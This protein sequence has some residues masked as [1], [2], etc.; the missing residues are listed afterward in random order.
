MFTKIRNSFTLQVYCFAAGIAL[1]CLLLMVLTWLQGPRVRSATLDANLVTTAANQQ[2][3]LHMNQPPGTISQKQVRITPEALFAVTSSGNTVAIQFTQ[4]L[5]NDT[6]YTVAI[7]TSNKRYTVNHT[8]HTAA[9]TFYYAVDSEYSTEIRK[10]TVGTDVSQAVYTGSQVDDYLVLGNTLVL[11]IKDGDKDTLLVYD[12]PSKQSQ[13]VTLPGNGTISQLHSAPGKRLFGFISTDYTS[14][15]TGTILLYDMNAQRLRRVGFS[16]DRP[17]EADEWQLARNGTTVLAQTLD[18]NALLLNPGATPIPLGQYTELFGFSHDDSSILMR[19]ATDGAISLNVK[20]KQQKPLVKQANDT[21]VTEAFPL[22][23]KQGY[24]VQVQT[25]TGHTSSAQKVLI[26]QQGKQKELYANT[27]SGQ[28][29][30]AVSLS[31]NDQ[32]LAV[33]ERTTESDIYQTRIIN[34]NSNGTLT[35][36]EGNMIRWPSGL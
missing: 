23:T 26:D 33:E 2:L 19:H 10:Q 11:A 6:D 35:I 13:R 3:L 4:P 24:I 9:A 1:I 12:M 8:F 27:S 20:S 22:S 29:I 16:Q 21:Y 36:V 7:Q 25:S 32:L 14:E 34:A 17:V 28:Y 31:P 30:D 18:A 15:V 5:Q